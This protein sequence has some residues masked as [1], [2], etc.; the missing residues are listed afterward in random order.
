MI[1]REQLVAKLRAIGF[2]YINRKKRVELYGKAGVYVTVPL[3]DLVEENLVRIVLG[4]AGLT[5]PQTNEFVIGC[6]K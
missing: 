1:S 5:V 6:V 2:H 4:Q 3:S